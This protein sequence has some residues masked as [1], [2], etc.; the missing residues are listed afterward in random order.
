L[1]IIKTSEQVEKIRKSGKLASRALDLVGEK[2]KPGVTSKYLDKL[3]HDFIT[4]NGGVPA[5][6]G[7]KI[8]DGEIPFSASCCVS[9]NEVVVHGIPSGRKIQDGDLVTVDVTAILDGFYADTARTFMVGN[10]PEA[11]RRL[12]EA[13]EESLRLA[14]NEV[15][16]KARLGDIGDAIESHVKSQ[17]FSVVR[18]FV[19]HGVGLAF[20]EPPDIPNFGEKGKG[21]RIYTGMV[22][23]IE[24][25]VNEGDHNVKILDDGWTAVTVDGKLSAQFEHTVVVTADGADILTLS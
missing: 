8:R 22:I 1:V 4:G 13:T 19:G 14:I 20:H 18:Y 11:G 16:D 17:G 7:Y 21:A 5:T 2:I 3:V 23:A 12:T 6:A 24:P 15:K 25:I 9:I 10:V